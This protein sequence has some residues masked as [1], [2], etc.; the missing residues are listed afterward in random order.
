MKKSLSGV[1]DD[2][3]GSE[4]P[5]VPCGL[6]KACLDKISKEIRDEGGGLIIEAPSALPGRNMLRR[7]TWGNNDVL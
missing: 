5:E 3:D 1:E 6:T 7:I 4:E 2:V